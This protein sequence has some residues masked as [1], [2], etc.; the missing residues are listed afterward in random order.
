[1]FSMLSLS[2]SSMGA[3]AASGI[4]HHACHLDHPTTSSSSSVSVTESSLSLSRVV[5]V[6][7]G[8]AARGGKIL[9]VAG[10]LTARGG[11]NCLVRFSLLAS[12]FLSLLLLLSLVPLFL[13]VLL[14]F[15][16]GCRHLRLL[17]DSFLFHFSKPI[18]RALLKQV[19]Q[20]AKQLCRTLYHTSLHLNGVHTSTTLIASI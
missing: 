11:N 2:L 4:D 14:R 9:V 13:F 18:M 19:F 6:A 7:G 20:E 17:S 12:L 1:M 3:A 15:G 16:G 8:L 10:D 5:H